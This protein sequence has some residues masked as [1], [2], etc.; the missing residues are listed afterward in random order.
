MI[1]NECHKNFSMDELWDEKFREYE[2]P[3]LLYDKIKT[4]LPKSD[5]DEKKPD[6]DIYSDGDKRYNEVNE[7]MTQQFVRIVGFSLLL[8][9]YGYDITEIITVAEEYIQD[10]VHNPWKEHGANDTEPRRISRWTFHHVVGI[11]DTSQVPF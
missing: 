6:W 2:I 5:W 11:I 7:L 8:Y 9:A 10:R 3:P 4:K 1:I